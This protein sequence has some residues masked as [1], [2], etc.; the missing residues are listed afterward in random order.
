MG[1]V[2]VVGIAQ[3]VVQGVLEVQGFS[4]RTSD[5]RWDG[6]VPVH[7]AQESR[8]GYCS[9]GDE[10]QAGICRTAMTTAETGSRLAAPFYLAQ[11]VVDIT[12]NSLL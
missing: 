2:E 3:E 6:V 1:V 10:W 12:L 8:K 5:G 11:R 9:G 4:R 7:V